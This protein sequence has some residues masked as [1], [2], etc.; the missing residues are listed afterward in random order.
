MYLPEALAAESVKEISVAFAVVYYAVAAHAEVG[1]MPAARAEAIKAANNF[2]FM[3]FTILSK[4]L[5]SD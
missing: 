2:F 1:S 4:G 3:V 5:Y